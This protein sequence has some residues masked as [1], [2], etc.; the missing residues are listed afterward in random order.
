MYTQME[1]L[2][3]ACAP[4]RC[5]ITASGYCRVSSDLPINMANQLPILEPTTLDMTDDDE[6]GLD[7]MAHETSRTTPLT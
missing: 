1:E 3:P 2:T 6:Y 5:A 4:V 7:V